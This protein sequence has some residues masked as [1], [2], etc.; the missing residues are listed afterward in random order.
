MINAN[1]LRIGNLICERNNHRIYPVLGIDKH[2]CLV[3]YWSCGEKEII[4]FN[5]CLPVP[6]NSEIL[7]MAGFAYKENIVMWGNG[8]DDLSYHYIELK[9]GYEL[10]IF[11]DGSCNKMD[12]GGV[13]T[14]LHQLQ[15][16]YYAINGEE[17]TIK[18]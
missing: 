6:I 13:L 7:E 8:P 1:E 10:K 12:S 14:S 16:L 2:G 4:R 17:L 5:K 3:K 11:A 15:N 18:L 9:S